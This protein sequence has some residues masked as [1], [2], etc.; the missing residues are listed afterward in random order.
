MMT[1][2]YKELIVGAVGLFFALLG[3]SFKKK[4][5]GH[6]DQSPSTVDTKDNRVLRS[7]N[8]T[9][10]KVVI[11]Q[12]N[13]FN[14]GNEKEFK[15]FVDALHGYPNLFKKLQTSFGIRFDKL[16]T[17]NEE[18]HEMLLRLFNDSPTVKD[19]ENKL[20]ELE[21]QNK[22]LLEHI[23]KLEKQ[24]EQN[25]EFQEVLKKAETALANKQF[26]QFHTL[27]EA[28]SSIK[29][30]QVERF[31]KEIAESA[32]LRA[33]E[34]AARLGYT[35]A[36]EQMAEAVQYDSG[37]GD[38]WNRY[39]FY[40]NVIARYQDAIDAYS[41]ALEIDLKTVGDKHPNIARSYNNL[42][43]TWH[44]LGDSKKAIGYYEKAIKID[45]AAL[46]ENHPSVARDY[47]NLGAAWNT[48]GDSKKA[49]DYYEKA[50]NIFTF[51]YGKDHPSTKTVQSNL[52]AV[53]SKKSA[54][55]EESKTTP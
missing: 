27:L 18:T 23:S 51:V 43:G 52:E 37:N 22:A 11:F 40:L 45:L 44:T 55:S 6:G 16:E 28:F 1:E 25:P 29:K 41:K 32:A 34:Y 3:W 39:G 49:I 53:T 13:S 48:L 20:D 47:N 38:Y 12:G 36:V 33:E 10:S 21:K 50:L 17:Q 19:L 30:K 15:K 46:G 31:S 35:G 7:G 2:F 54:P 42:G 4:I 14:L 8:I 5:G 24:Q 26:D 9:N